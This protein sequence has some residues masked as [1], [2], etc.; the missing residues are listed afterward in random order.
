MYTSHLRRLLE[1]KYKNLATFHAIVTFRVERETVGHAVTILNFR[2]KASVQARFTEWIKP[3]VKSLHAVAYQYTGSKENAE[4]LV[5]EVIA[6]VYAKNRWQDIEHPKAWLMRCLYNRF[7][8]ICRKN[9][10]QNMIDDIDDSHKEIVGN[11][12]AETSVVVDQVHNAIQ[13]LPPHQRALVSLCDINGYSLTELSKTL[14]KPLGTLKSD[15][16]RG[17]Q[18]LKQ[19]L[20]LSGHEANMRLVVGGAE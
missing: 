14:D 7:I 16:H 12:S 1:I 5:Q 2:K 13:Q 15:L 9:K 10:Y 19:T 4:D 18:K 11:E 17:R 8:D 3:F 6:D 20:K